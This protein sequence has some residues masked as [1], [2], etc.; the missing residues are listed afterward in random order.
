MIN[1]TGKK[2]QI[3]VE[4]MIVA[5]FVIFLVVCILSIAF[6]YSNSIRDGIRVYNL[7]NF[8]NKVTSSAESVFYAGYPSQATITA[9]LP[10][11]VQSVI[12]QDNSIVANIST[13][14]GVAT[15][16]YES[17]VPISGSITATGGI[18]TIKLTAETD[19]VS[20]SSN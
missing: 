10:E 16:A 11:G 17:E 8:G 6:F 3:S 13:S 14:S 7:N 18:K 12:I 1:A 19:K 9:Y 20:I 4:Y 5:G 2:G 15:I